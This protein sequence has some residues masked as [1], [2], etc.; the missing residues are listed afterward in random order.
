MNAPHPQ[1]Q[2]LAEAHDRAQAERF[3]PSPAAWASLVADIRKNLLES[4]AVVFKGVDLTCF[5]RFVPNTDGYCDNGGFYLRR[6][7]HCEDDVMALLSPDDMV[8]LSDQCF[9]EY[10]RDAKKAAEWKP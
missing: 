4:V 2:Q 8:K 6:V 7:E 10:E 3:V 9:T 1:Q 5:G